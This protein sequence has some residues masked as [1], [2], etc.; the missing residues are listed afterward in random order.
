MCRSDMS[1]IS[2]KM[3]FCRLHA[4]FEALQT[5]PGWAECYTINFEQLAAE[6]NQVYEQLLDALRVKGEYDVAV[7]LATLLQQPISDIVYSKW[8]TKLEAS[9]SVDGGEE[10]YAASTF[11][12]YENEIAEHSLPPELLVNFYLYAAGRLTRSCARKYQLLKRAL[13]VIKQHH[14]FP[15]ESFDR[16]QIEYGMIICYLQLDDNVAAE[17]SVYHSE[18]Y[19][20]IMLNER[21]VLYKSFLELKELAGI[22]DLN[23]SIKHPMT[24]LME[25]RLETLLNLLLDKGDI[26]EALRLQELFECR[27]ID[28][29]FVVFCMALAE[30]V[31]TIFSMSSEERQM[32][33][34][35]EISSFAKFNKRTLD[36]GLLTRE[37]VFVF[38]EIYLKRKNI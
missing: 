20:Q 3:D 32:L 8:V 34:D 24:K 38:G 23:V 27:P 14:L 25:A 29:R 11:Q 31:T 28:L 37:G 26:V 18:Y 5:R 35:I 16:D 9:E 19:E 6:N 12:L 4:V 21:C 2:V 33:R 15:N 17:M 30:G 7:R 36:S 1:D 22:E 10:P 13:T